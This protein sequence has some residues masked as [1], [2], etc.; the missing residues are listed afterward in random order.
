MEITLETPMP[1]GKFKGQQPIDMLAED[2]YN[3]Y[4]LFGNGDPRAYLKWWNKN[5]VEH[6]LAK[7]VIA[8]VNRREKQIGDLQ[9]EYE[10][11]NPRQSLGNRNNRDM[12]DAIWMHEVHGIS[13]WGEW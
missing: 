2:N 1:Y 13:M 4:S 3:E 10:R 5:V 12:D 9:R 7:E 11:K 8:M 6:P